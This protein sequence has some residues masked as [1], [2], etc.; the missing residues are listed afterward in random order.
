MI[1]LIA[2]G[3][4]ERVAAKY[5]PSF[6]L[7]KVS[8]ICKACIID[9]RSGDK[10]SGAIDA[11]PRGKYCC[12]W[13]AHVEKRIDDAQHLIDETLRNGAKRGK[14]GKSFDSWWV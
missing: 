10:A 11:K 2:I 8:D 5:G 4:F 9:R 14:V 13:R 12:S 6:L 1:M 7:W 3:R